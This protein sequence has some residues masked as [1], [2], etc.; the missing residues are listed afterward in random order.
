MKTMLGKSATAAALIFTLITSAS[1]SVHAAS[2]IKAASSFPVNSPLIYDRA[3][4]P[5]I[6]ITTEA[7]T[8]G[9]TYMVYDRNGNMIM[10][11]TVKPGKTSFISTKNL[12]DGTYRFHIGNTMIQ[13][14]TVQ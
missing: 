7:N 14:F 3:T 4:H 8:A 1:K 13:T 6:G 10:T 2:A 12:K 9:Q 11:G 5:V